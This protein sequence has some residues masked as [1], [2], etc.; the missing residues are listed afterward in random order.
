MRLLFHVKYQRQSIARKILYNL[1][2]CIS[3]NCYW[4]YF[5]RITRF[6]IKFQCTGFTRRIRKH[7]GQRRYRGQKTGKQSFRLVH[8]SWG[9]HR[10]TC[11]CC[12]R[13]DGAP[14]TRPLSGPVTGHSIGLRQ[15]RS[16]RVTNCTWASSP[17]TRA[18]SA[19]SSFIS[20]SAS[21]PTGPHTNQTS[22]KH[23]DLVVVDRELCWTIQSFQP[24]HYHLHL[25][26]ALQRSQINRINLSGRISKALLQL[27]LCSVSFLLLRPP[28]TVNWSLKKYMRYLIL[29]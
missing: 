12:L 26:W 15:L 8:R 13:A 4:H 1:K 16:S 14:L 19:S 22:S 6:S 23:V 29:K 18:A 11:V 25:F 24:L 20:F 7:W 5:T 27:S 2:N 9:T 21:F 3:I 10:S 17:Q 28:A